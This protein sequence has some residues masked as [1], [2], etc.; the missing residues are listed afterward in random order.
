MLFRNRLFRRLF[1]GHIVS[2]A[3]DTLYLVAAL[4][5]VYMLTGSSTY[6][7]L[8][9]A[10]IRAPRFFRAFTGPLVDRWPLRI[11]LV[12]SEL[13]QG[14]SILAVPLAAAFGKLQV[15]VVLAVLPVVA[16]V[17]QFAGPA[18]SA[19]LPRVIDQENMVSANSTIQFSTQ[20]V[21]AIT[22][23]VAGA[24]I[25]AIGAVAL[26]LVDA[27]TFAAA[28]VTF[29]TI[30][31]PGDETAEN[32]LPTRSE[33]VAQ[34][35]AGV[36][37]L[38]ES[39]LGHM[40]VA[41][42]GLTLFSSGAMAVLPAFAAS[43]GG[44]GTYGFFLAAFAVGTLTG[45]L[46]AGLIDTFPT[47]RMVILGFVLAALSWTAAV[48][49]S[50]V[51]LAVAFFALA[52]VPIG[53]YNVLAM[54]ALQVGVPDEMV[55]RVSAVTGTFV[56]VA[57]LFG[58]LAGGVGGDAFGAVSVLFAASIGFATAA[59]YWVGVPALRTFPAITDLEPGEFAS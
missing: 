3:G 22:R 20:S 21:Q 25:A 47:G 58:M 12:L 52:Y 54:S 15:S 50:W 46:L 41:V 53:V 6:T 18:Q 1:S 13:V 8:A 38:R 31:I 44:P 43:V 45:T 51:P 57:G 7:G 34:L 33:Y 49:V 32:S 16:F 17:G 9:G 2:V 19:T 26:F 35:R 28:A 23:A 59:I 5:L 39:V 42:A 27:I 36:T 24:A 55:G 48:V 14:I 56:G 10:L 4:W 37:L 11:I 40:V 29:A 30:T